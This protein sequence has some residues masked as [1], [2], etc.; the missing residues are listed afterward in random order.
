MGLFFPSHSN[1][2]SLSFLFEATREGL[3]SAS[4]WGFMGPSSTQ[5]QGFGLLMCV[6]LQFTLWL[7]GFLWFSTLSWGFGSGKSWDCKSTCLFRIIVSLWWCVAFFYALNI[8]TLEEWG[9][10]LLWSVSLFRANRQKE[11]CKGR[12]AV[13]C[14]SSFC[15]V[16]R[17][18]SLQPLQ[19]SFRSWLPRS[20]AFTPPLLRVVFSTTCSCW[21]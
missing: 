15:S 7:V 16:I 9:R 12:W 17:V 2:F 11:F 21:R 3:G 14:C 6:I 1:C 4:H 13:F 10:L 8:G 18:L 19:N 20:V 5:Y